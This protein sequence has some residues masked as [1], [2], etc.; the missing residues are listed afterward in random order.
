MTINKAQGQALLE[1][2]QAFNVFLMENCTLSCHMRF[3]I[4]LAV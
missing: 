2:T 3:Q 4:K 1:L